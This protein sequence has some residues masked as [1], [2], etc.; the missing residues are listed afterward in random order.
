MLPLIIKTTYSR[1]GCQD[2]S[3]PLEKTHYLSVLLKPF[4][5]IDIMWFELFAFRD[6]LFRPHDFEPRPNA[7]AMHRLIDLR[8]FSPKCSRG[9]SDQQIV[10]LSLGARD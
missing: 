4:E 9:V 8:F 6:R 2:K 1:P 7:G 3:E 10:F 5:N